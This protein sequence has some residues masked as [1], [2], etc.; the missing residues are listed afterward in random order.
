VTDP[1]ESYKLYNALKLHFESDYDAVKYNFKSNV[2]PNSFF[3][4]KD[5]YFFAKIAKNQKDL[6]HYYVFNFIEDVKYIGDMED[7]HYTKHR[8]VHDSLTRTFESDI[9]TLA[10][11]S[12]DDLLTVKT[13]NQAPMIVEKWMH[14]EIT[15]ETLVILNALT[16]FVYKEGSKIS[17]TI[18]WPDVSRKITKYSPFVKFDRTRYIKIIKNAFTLA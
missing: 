3:K 14:E 6:L 12:F 9:N 15:L 18:F 4:R 2:T 7:S 16:D 5:K 10:E 13:T 8:K 17:E 1:F 11:H